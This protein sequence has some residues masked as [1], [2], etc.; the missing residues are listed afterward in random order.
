MLEEVTL[1]RIHRFDPNDVQFDDALV[2]SAV[3]FLR[4]TRPAKDHEV[5]FS[6]GGT[7]ASPKSS[8]SLKASDLRQVSKW[9]GLPINGS[10]IRKRSGA[11][12]GDLFAIKRGLATGCNEFFVLRSEQ[13]AEWNLPDEFLI[14]ILPSPR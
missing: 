2:S 1:H 8:Q 12:L 9:T 6:F 5:E 14:P 3:L 7:V 10:D 11:T 4:N 13:I